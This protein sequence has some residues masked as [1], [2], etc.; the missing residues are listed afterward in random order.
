MKKPK[1]L[2]LISGGLDSILATWLILQQGVEVIGITFSTPF[3]DLEKPKKACE[4]LKIPLHIVDI[5][6]EFL[7]ILKSPKYGYGKNMNPCI[8]CHSY[9]IKKAKELL[10][11][12]DADFI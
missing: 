1:A 6:E 2:S 10:K 11:K 7:Q 4:F 5:T 9:M 8:D 12:F 3:F